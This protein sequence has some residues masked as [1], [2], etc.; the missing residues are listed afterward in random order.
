MLY[1]AELFHTSMVKIDGG[2]P[3]YDPRYR[4]SG[5]WGVILSVGGESNKRGAIFN[6]SVGS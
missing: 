5:L 6:K 3:K 1:R 2:S 4:I